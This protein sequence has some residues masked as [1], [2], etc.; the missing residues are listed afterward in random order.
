MNTSDRPFH[1]TSDTEVIIK[2]YQHWGIEAVHRF[3]GMFAFALFDRKKNILYL[4]RD[5]AGVKPL[6]YYHHEDCI[7]F[8]SELKA[9]HQYP[10]FKKEI[11]EKGFRYFSSM[12]ISRL[13]IQFLKTLYKLQA[14]HYLE[15]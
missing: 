7:L 8:A 3:I 15:N 12:L 1:S 13:L 14:G 10:V 2:A 4:F 9:L 5:R 6:Y 11:N